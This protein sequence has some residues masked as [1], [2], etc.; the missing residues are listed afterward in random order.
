MFGRQ[1]FK[2]FASRGRFTI[3]AVLFTFALFSAVSVALSVRATARAE[4]Q[5]EVVQVA[6]RQRTLAERYV[7]DVLL[8]RS[9]ARADPAYTASI[10]RGSA[11][12]LLNGGTA[13]AVNGDDDDHRLTAVRT[14]TARGQLEQAHRLVQDLTATVPCPRFA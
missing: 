2:P 3:A 7:Q 9:G 13:P 11:N 6:A 1:A 4:H 12:A 8:V 14:K 10:L 5:A